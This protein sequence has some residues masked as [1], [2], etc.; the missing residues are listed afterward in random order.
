MNICQ[1]RAW[2]LWTEIPAREKSLTF[3]AQNGQNLDRHMSH[4]NFESISYF[5]WLFFRLKNEKKGS[6]CFTKVI[7]F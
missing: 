6:G 7:L 5:A 3:H 4:A 2:C 1:C